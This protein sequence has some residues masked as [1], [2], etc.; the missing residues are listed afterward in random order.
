MEQE[1]KQ[2]IFPDVFLE[3]QPLEKNRGRIPGHLSILCDAPENILQWVPD[4][5]VN[6]A[7]RVEFPVRELTT[8]RRS[9]GPRVTFVLSRGESIGPFQFRAGQ[10]DYDRLLKAFAE[11]GI[12]AHPSETARSDWFSNLAGWMG[13]VRQQ[14]RLLTDDD[15]VIN[16]MPFLPPD[17]ETHRATHLH[18]QPP[19][20][21]PADVVCRRTEELGEMGD[22]EVLD[23]ASLLPPRESVEREPPVD[24]KEWDSFFK[25]GALI[26]E[27]ELR[28]RVFKGGLTLQARPRAWKYFL[29]Y[30]DENTAAYKSEYNIMKQQW[31]SL[32]ESQ[33]QNNKRMRELISLVEKDVYR[34]DRTHP[35]F[36][37]E[38]GEG[39][40]ALNDILL[41]F[42]VYNFDLGYVQGMSDLVAVLYTVFRDEVTTF[43]CFVHW[44]ETLAPNFDCRQS[45]ILSQLSLLVALIKY[46]DPELM[47]H[48]EEQ[49]T[50][51]LFFCFRWLIVVFKREFAFEDV[52]TIWEV[53]WSEYLSPDF[54]VFICAAM[55]LYARKQ[56]LEA[57]QSY[58]EILK[59]FNELAHQLTCEQVLCEAE[60]ICHQLRA[61]NE[62]DLP[63]LLHPLRHTWTDRYEPVQPLEEENEE[64][65][66]EPWP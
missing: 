51:H 54:P 15:S 3:T 5:E 26:N 21:Q 1:P 35:L 20:P 30:N 19:P 53:I 4:I 50:E 17:E 62:Q 42:G 63:V 22:F 12:V 58:D 45:G 28:R 41:T 25:D 13:T 43:W 32:T 2:Y 27:V 52:M 16:R 9:N 8:L 11:L 14:L 7:Y 48:L 24:E 55:I 18:E 44:M 37:E 59:T 33:I 40:C 34:T 61:C 49:K 38:G 23:I 65:S 10:V 39:F 47:S 6:M 66:E 60:S 36:R 29:R 57:K 31:K 46:I 64:P 56:I